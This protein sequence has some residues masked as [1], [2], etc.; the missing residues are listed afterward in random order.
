MPS[1]EMVKY[2]P[3]MR[4]RSRSQSHAPAS[5]PTTPVSTVSVPKVRFTLARSSRPASLPGSA[6]MRNTAT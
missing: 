4:G 2:E 1:P 3:G 6:C 5:V